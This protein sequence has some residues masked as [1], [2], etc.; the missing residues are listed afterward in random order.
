MCIYSWMY[1][2]DSAV[3][4][5]SSGYH[6]W[7]IIIIIIQCFLEKLVKFI[8]GLLTA[9]MDPKSTWLV[10]INISIHAAINY[11]PPSLSFS[12]QSYWM[13]Y[14]IYLVL[15]LRMNNAIYRYISHSSSFDF[16]YDAMWKLHTWQ[17]SRFMMS[18]QNANALMAVSSQVEQQQSKLISP[19]FASHYECYQVEGF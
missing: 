16:G 5:H 14:H 1:S 6:H 15:P 3:Q 4:R 12:G 18:H 7:F 17:S 2:A 11:A 19:S 8:R 10:Y 9:S 13:Q